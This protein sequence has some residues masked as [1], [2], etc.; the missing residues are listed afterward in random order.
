MLRPKTDGWSSG[1]PLKRLLN[2]VYSF[3]LYGS[4]GKT[5][6]TKGGGGR[7]TKSKKTES[8]GKAFILPKERGIQLGSLSLAGWTTG[9]LHDRARGRGTPV[10]VGQ[11]NVPLYCELGASKY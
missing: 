10:I 3:V 4:K 1:K 8:P 9:R 2:K 5:K 11:R 7:K 6:S